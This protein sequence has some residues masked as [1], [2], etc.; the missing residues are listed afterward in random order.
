MPRGIVRDDVP[1]KMLLIGDSGMGK[2]GA[3]ASLVKEGYRVI[4]A[5]FDSGLESLFKELEKLPSGSTDNFYYETFTDPMV[6]SGGKILPAGV[7][8]AYSGFVNGLTRWKF[9]KGDD[10]YDLGKITSWGGNTVFVIDSLTH[11]GRAAMRHVQAINGQLGKHPHPGIYGQAM[12]LIESV[13][14]LLYGS[15]I[16]CNVIVNSHISFHDDTEAVIENKAALESDSAKADFSAPIRPQ[17][18]FPMALGDKLP[19]KVGSYFN[20]CVRVKT[21]GIGSSA[22]RIIRTSTEGV[23]GLK[24]PHG[25]TKFPDEVPLSTGLADIFKYLK[26]GKHTPYV[27]TKEPIEAA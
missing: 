19:P 3:L 1:V 6:S 2:T 9:G 4:V 16:N 23:V 17:K 8:V 22:K 20:I 26:G 14:T 15:N 10:A 27:E 12:E 21:K 11:L 13:L 18:G 5:D 7:P 24:F 25:A